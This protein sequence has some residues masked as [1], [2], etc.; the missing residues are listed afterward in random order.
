MKLKY[1]S[2][3]FGEAAWVAGG[4]FLIGLT[5][6]SYPA[7]EISSRVPNARPLY[8]PNEADRQ[9]ESAKSYLTGHPDDFNT[10]IALAMA[11]YAKG[12]DHYVEAMNALEKARALGATSEHLFFYAGTMYEAL[13]L[14]DYAIN[15][16]AKYLRHHPNDY[17]TMIRLANLHF[18]QK[19]TDDAQALY[20]DALHLW[21]KDA[22]AWFNY[23]IINKEKGNYPVA[24]NC[25]DQVVKIAGRL[26]AGGLF[27]E[28]EIY[29]LKGDENKALQ[30]YQQELAAQP[31]YIPALEATE[32]IIRAKGDIK[33]A[34]NIH[35]RIVEL[36]HQQAQNQR[37]HG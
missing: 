22:T 34:R 2:N 14:P 36:K 23:A 3:Y 21:P 37:T 27:E 4:L 33:Q 19:H 15:E 26:P 35:K 31:G 13:G 25:L 6:H 5:L 29:R 16:L 8:S 11:Y 32:T 12:P 28:G 20:K 7:F 17:E 18:R 24:L 30:Y 9:I 10:Y 1:E